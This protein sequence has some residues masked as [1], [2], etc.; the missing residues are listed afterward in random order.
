MEAL[1]VA[2]RAIAGRPRT[3]SSGLE[4]MA[5]ILD[6][7]SVKTTESGGPRGY[8]VGKKIKGRKRQLAIDVEGLLIVVQ[9]AAA[10]DGFFGSVQ[11]RD[12]AP[13]L[14]LESLTKSPAVEKLFADGG[15]AGPK[16]AGRLDLKQ[17]RTLR[18]QRSRTC[19]SLGARGSRTARDRTQA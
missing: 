16:L 7:Q 5:A 13:P 4:S 6:G 15:Y 18:V 17:K 3:D 11:D 19:P 9:V 14:I 1:Q 10:K 2:S 12:S 8:D